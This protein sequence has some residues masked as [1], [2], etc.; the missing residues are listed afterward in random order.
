MPQ[1][2]NIDEDGD[3]ILVVGDNQT[4]LKID[5]YMLKKA[6]KVF[7]AMFQPNAF[8]EGQNLSSDATTKEQLLPE[9]DPQAMKLLCHIIHQNSTEIPDSI[10]DDLLLSVA[11]HIDKYFLHRVSG[12]YTDHWFT[13]KSLYIGGS[14]HKVL[15]AA[16]IRRKKEPFKYLTRSI[17]L[18]Q[19]DS[20]VTM[21]DDDAPFCMGK[22]AC[23]LE[24]DRSR[25]RAELMANLHLVLTPWPTHKCECS[26]NYM[27]LLDKELRVKSFTFS[28]I[29][30]K[31]LSDCACLLRTLPK[32]AKCTKQRGV[33]IHCTQ[34]IERCAKLEEC[35]SNVE[36]YYGKGYALDDY[37]SN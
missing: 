16:I 19:E 3:L 28:T 14:R 18:H 34:A 24:T 26:S 12:F 7:K 15:I 5:S 29:Q 17:L 35:I 6:S 13:G 10:D 23:A 8:A 36:V 11:R 9:D 22:I 20:Y 1:T 27:T 2:I 30:A 25:I 4:R 31:S 32:P 37:L 21:I 33:G